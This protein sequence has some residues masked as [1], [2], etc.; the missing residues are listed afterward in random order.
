MTIRHILV[1]VDFTAISDRI[2]DF[3]RTVAAGVNAEVHLVHVLEEPY[4]SAG[5]Y[6]FHLPDTPARRERLYTQARS[7]LGLLADEMRVKDIDT[8][9][10][11]RSGSAIDEIIK[12]AIDYGADLIVMGTHGRSGLQHLL[13]G[14]VAQE[15]IRRA[16][17]PVLAIRNHGGVIAANAA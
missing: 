4:A 15:I 6:Q 5:S 2:V 13:T 7:R 17:C 10:E 8:T 1:P 3:A 16:P 9:L 11:V 14:S 12:A